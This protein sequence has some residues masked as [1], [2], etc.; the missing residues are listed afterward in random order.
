MRFESWKGGGGDRL[1][2]GGLATYLTFAMVLS[3]FY[4]ITWLYNSYNS[5]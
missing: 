3:G 1:R 5:A 2:G 4:M